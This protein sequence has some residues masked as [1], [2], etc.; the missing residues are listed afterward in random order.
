MKSNLTP[1]KT[2]QTDQTYTG[3][4]CFTQ[5]R[6]GETLFAVDATP[7]S[8]TALIQ[9]FQLSALRRLETT[10]LKPSM[11]GLVKTEECGGLTIDGAREFPAPPGALTRKDI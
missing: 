2:D 1:L 9:Q 3:P 8:K 10:H 11:T 6:Q 5:Q 7:L 4:I